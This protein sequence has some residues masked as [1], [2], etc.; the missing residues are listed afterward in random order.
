M[1]DLGTVEQQIAELKD[2]LTD[3]PITILINR[4]LQIVDLARSYVRVDTGA[5]RSDIR[6]EI[7]RQGA[8]GASVS[9]AAGGTQINPKTGKIVDY[10]QAIETKYPFIYPAIS[11]IAP[12]IKADLRALHE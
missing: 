7:R 4:G 3:A 10:A 5:L 8:G 2:L 6:M 1:S 11:S 12:M 9:I